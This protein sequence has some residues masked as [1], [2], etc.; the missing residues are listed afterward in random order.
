M[1]RT[2]ST[3]PQCLYSRAIPLLPLWAIWPV[4]SLSACTVELYL[5]SLWAIWPV[6]SLSALQGCTLPICKIKNTNCLE[7]GRSPVRFKSKVGGGSNIRLYLIPKY[8]SFSTW[9]HVSL[10]VPAPPWESIGPSQL[11]CKPPGTA[12]SKM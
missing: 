4:Q 12:Y 11:Q 3:E 10:F 9:G 8:A 5:Y 1:G 2:V 6:Q 7:Q